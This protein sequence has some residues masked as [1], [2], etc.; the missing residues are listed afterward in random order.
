MLDVFNTLLRHLRS[1]VDSQLVASDS[2]ILSSVGEQR[3]V[4]QTD[5]DSQLEATVA[6]ER[7]FQNAVVDTVGR[8]HLAVF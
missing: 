2:L 7:Q 4:F 3:V 1:S 6:V 5:T 8:T